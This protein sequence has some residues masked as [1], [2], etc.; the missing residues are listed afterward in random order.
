MENLMKE[1]KQQLLSVIGSPS[2][3]PMKLKELAILLDVPRERRE[4]LEEVL[5][6]L[7]DGNG[8]CEER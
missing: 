7:Y 1:R 6:A 5:E 8:G 3:V 2:Y 4:E